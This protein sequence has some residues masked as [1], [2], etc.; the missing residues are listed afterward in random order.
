MINLETNL[1]KFIALTLVIYLLLKVN[2][3]IQYQ[4]TKKLLK[5]NWD[6]Y[7]IL[8][9]RYYS[10]FRSLNTCLR[11]KGLNN[12]QIRTIFKILESSKLIKVNY[13]GD[14]SDI[15]ITDKYLPRKLN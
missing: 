8:F 7:R 3:I 4:R 13:L 5:R 11:E 6:E 15:M 10:N 14:D 9:D 12:R 1:E 2:D